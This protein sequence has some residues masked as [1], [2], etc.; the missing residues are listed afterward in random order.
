[1]KKRK[2]TEAKVLLRI[3][4]GITEYIFPTLGN[5]ADIE[6]KKILD[7]YKLPKYTEIGYR[8]RVVR[9]LRDWVTLKEVYIKK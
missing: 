9:Q 6:I 3:K 2:T 7:F 1:M 4:K 5:T 8:Y